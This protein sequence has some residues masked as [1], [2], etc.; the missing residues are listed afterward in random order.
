MPLIGNSYNQEKVKKER[1]LVMNHLP[2]SEDEFETSKLL[3]QFSHDGSAKT[4]TYDRTPFLEIKRQAVASV[5][6]EDSSYS[7]I[8][9]FSVTVL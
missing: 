1:E 9:K 4:F 3:I 7:L 5:D 8:E 2:V 6:N